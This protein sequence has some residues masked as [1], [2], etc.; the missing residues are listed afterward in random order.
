MI[1][2]GSESGMQEGSCDSQ[3]VMSKDTVGYL[4]CRT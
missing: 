3:D 1:L 4:V 2:E